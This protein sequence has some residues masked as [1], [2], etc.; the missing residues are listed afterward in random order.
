LGHAH[1]PTEAQRIYGASIVGTQLREGGAM[2]MA[3][4]L[5]LGVL[6]R[7]VERALAVAMSMESDPLVLIRILS[8]YTTSHRRAMAHN[9]E[10]EDDGG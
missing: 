9:T 3:E 5:L 8:N 6:P 2:P 4:I 7:P 1:H 10:E